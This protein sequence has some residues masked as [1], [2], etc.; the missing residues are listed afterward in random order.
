MSQTNEIEKKTDQELL[1]VLLSLPAQEIEKAREVLGELVERDTFTFSS[2]VTRA[3]PLI[4]EAFTNLDST[5]NILLLSPAEIESFQSEKKRMFWSSEAPTSFWRIFRTNDYQFM[6]FARFKASEEKKGYSEIRDF[7]PVES[8]KREGIPPFL[9]C[10]KLAGFLTRECLG[11]LPDHKRFIDLCAGSAPLFFAKRKSEEEEL[12]F[13]TQELRDSYL[14]LQDASS[15]SMEKLRKLCWEG[16]SKTW[17]ALLDSAPETPMEEFHK[18]A[19]LTSFSYNNHGKSFAE[20]RKKSHWWGLHLLGA[21]K[22]RLRG[23]KLSKRDPITLLKEGDEDTLFLLQPLFPLQ[24]SEGLIRALKETKSKVLLVDP[25]FDPPEGYGSWHVELRKDGEGFSKFHQISWNFLLEEDIFSKVQAKDLTELSDQDLIFLHGQIHQEWEKQ[26]SRE[27]DEPAINAHLLV[28]HEI[29]RRGLEHRPKTALDLLCLEADKIP[30][31]SVL[32]YLNHSFSVSDPFLAITGSQAVEGGGND[33]D[34]WIACD[35][36]SPLASIVS[37]RLKSLL[38]EK[39]KKRIHL[40]PDPRGPFTNYIPLARLKVE[41][42][43]PVRQSLIAMSEEESSEAELDRVFARAT[44]QLKSKVTAGIFIIPLKTKAGYRKGETYSIPALLE[45]IGEDRYPWV[46]EQKFDGMRLQIHRHGDEVTIFSL[47]GKKVTDRFP[48]TVALMKVPEDDQWVLDSECTAPGMGRSD[49]AGYAH[50]KDKP[51]DSVF[52]M[53]VFDCLRVKDRDLHMETLRVRKSVLTA[54]RDQLKDQEF[55]S[56]ISI[57]DYDVAETEEQ[58]K[59]AVEHFGSLPG[60]EG[61]ML[62]AYDSNYPLIGETKDWVK[63]KKEVDIDA[64]VIQKV[65]TKGGAAWNY[66]CIVRDAGGKQVPIGK[67]YN[68]KED[69]PVGA[70]I[71]VGFGNL[72]KYTDPKTGEIWY[73]WVFPRFIERR[74]DKKKPDTVRTAERIHRETNGE[75]DEKP[76]PRRYAALLKKTLELELNTHPKNFAVMQAHF[77]GKSVHFDW[78]IKMNGYLEG[79]TLL[80]QP[81]DLVLEPVLTLAQGREIVKEN[82]NKWKFRPDMDPNK[83]C[84][85]I[86]KAR[87]P[88]EWLDV[89]PGI[90]EPGEVGATKEYPAVFILIDSGPCYPGVSKPYFKEYFFDMKKFKGRVVVRVVSFEDGPEKKARLQWQAWMTKKDEA[91]QVPYLLTR[92]ARTRKDYVPEEGKSALPP[93]WESQV[94][95][96]FRWWEKRLPRGEMLKRMDLAYNDLIH[97]KK[98]K[99]RTIEVKK[100]VAKFAL[101]LLWWKGQTVIRDV[102]NRQWD[103]LIDTGEKTLSRFTLQKDPLR[104]QKVVATRTELS[105]RTPD[106]K[107]PYA[108]LSW[109]GQLPPSHPDNP[110]KKLPLMVNIQDSGPGEIYEETDVF[111]SMKFLGKK[112]KGFWVLR[113]EDPTSEIWTFEQSKISVV[114]RHLEKAFVEFLEKDDEKRFVLGPVLLPETKDAQGSIISVETIEET[115]HD[116]MEKKGHIGVSHRDWSHR[117]EIVES[118]ILR[119]DLLFGD[120]KLPQGTWILGVKVLSDEIWEKVKSGELRG[121]SIQ[122]WA[123]VREED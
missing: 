60:S 94:A 122:G 41:M 25:G 79:W 93:W 49:V 85:A 100:K 63:Y 52:V 80:C 86:P 102:P 58:V 18:T 109:E 54:L 17:K 68:T 35:P 2:S 44:S 78:R 23:V 103:L 75:V 32:D 50:S 7:I 48:R 92:R 99:A 62:K 74:E 97:R 11:F 46:I 15:Q 19:Y 34:I 119:G 84:V 9:G 95:P 108:W 64:E 117:I 72:N 24:G 73:N 14:F 56:S 98:I 101:R 112:F 70:I 71:R 123:H 111:L 118:Y 89:A 43:P 83:K 77:R 121:F 33:I 47:N 21:A 110:T 114:V 31:D 82:A 55:S 10:S 4:E 27:N 65:Q 8:R 115:A 76:Y 20:S 45:E 6:G 28:L 30:L 59:K 26:G 40:V 12:N 107:P 38:P 105:R 104:N 37:F 36:D 66:L 67:T 57:V 1:H 91:S 53:N 61:A 51:D 106:G 90:K 29:N 3:S 22:E 87:Q 120:R 16:D 81:K 113:R 39:L 42:L 96:Q 5:R 13:P 69:V 88:L 116:F